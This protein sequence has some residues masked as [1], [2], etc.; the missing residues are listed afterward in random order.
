MRSI[1]IIAVLFVL[2]LSSCD[3]EKEPSLR[4][5][6]TIEGT[7][8]STV[9]IG[10]LMWTST[11]Y[12][13]PGGVQYDA[14]NSKPEYGKYYTLAEVNAITLPEGWRIPTEEDY[15][16]LAEQVGITT[17]PTTLVDSEKVGKITSKDHWN[18]TTGTNAT[19]FN[20]YPTGYI[21]G[22]SLPIDG[23]IAEFWTAG[24]LT[25]SIQ[26]AGANLSSLRMTFY[27]SDTSPDYR[28]T[29]RFV[30]DI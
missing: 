30:R 1:S 2:F 23:D 28:F 29:V 3:D 19:G 14:S 16:A 15:R 9:T 21:F 24:G 26:E 25:F 7:V 27:Q 17:I 8:Y 13:G 4:N 22:N 5:P 10:T 12:E 6:V 20:A 18:N 11:N